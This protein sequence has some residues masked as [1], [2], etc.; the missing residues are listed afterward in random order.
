MLRPDP[1]QA[2]RLIEIIDNLQARLS[3]AHHQGWLGEVEGIEISLTGARQK[4]D[5][6]QAAQTRSANSL[7]NL[8][9]P[10][11]SPR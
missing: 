8:G 1:Q 10:T 5:Q 6:I 11:L 2:P 9:L 7:V 3:E 4:L